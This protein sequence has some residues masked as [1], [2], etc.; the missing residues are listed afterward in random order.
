LRSYGHVIE[1]NNSEAVRVVMVM[2]KGGD[3]VIRRFKK[4][5]L[6]GIENDMI[7]DGVSE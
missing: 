3:K 2:H 7:I 4:R 6:V 1:R 5:C